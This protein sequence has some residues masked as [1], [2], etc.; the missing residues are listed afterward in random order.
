M[1]IISR[2]RKGRRKWKEMSS[3]GGVQDIIKKAHDEVKWASDP[4]HDQ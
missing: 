2:R 3:P 4:T 1:Y